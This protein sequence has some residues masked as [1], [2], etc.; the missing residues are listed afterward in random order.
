MLVKSFMLN[1]TLFQALISLL[2]SL[3]PHLTISTIVQYPKSHKK[4]PTPISPFTP[5][6]IQSTSSLSTT[7]HFAKF[8][9][10]LTFLNPHAS[11]RRQ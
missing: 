7:F 1:N 9:Q 2:S 4:H 3:D 8:T 11:T 10:K 6:F 5:F